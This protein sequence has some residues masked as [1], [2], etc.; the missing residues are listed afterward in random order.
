MEIWFR[1]SVARN[2]VPVVIIFF[3]SD[4]RNHFFFQIDRVTPS[5]R[6]LDLSPFRRFGKIRGLNQLRQQFSH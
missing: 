2:L 5:N 3:R 4:Q 6:L 1:I